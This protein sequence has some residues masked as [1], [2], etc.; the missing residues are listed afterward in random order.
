[1]EEKLISHI[2]QEVSR[3]FPEV[4]GVYPII[5]PHGSGQTLLIFHGKALAA[6]G[7]SI[8]RTV[9]AVADDQGSIIKITTSR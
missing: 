2:C 9:R 5:K 8:N 1:M 7:R 6:G 4:K 3:Q